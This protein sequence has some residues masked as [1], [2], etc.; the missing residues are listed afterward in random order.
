VILLHRYNVDG[1]VYYQVHL[2]RPGVEVQSPLLK[3]G[4]VVEWIMWALSPTSTPSSSP[5]NS[6]AG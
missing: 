1:E 4:E 2:S 6:K 3:R 5:S